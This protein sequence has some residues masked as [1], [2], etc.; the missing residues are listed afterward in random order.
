MSAVRQCMTALSAKAAAKASSPPITPA[1]LIRQGI[2][3]TPLS[4]PVPQIIAAPS[5][6]VSVL[7]A[8]FTTVPP[9]RR[10]M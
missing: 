9:P 6:T 1:L 8:P 2:A 7:P 10:T 3:M 4:I 5:A